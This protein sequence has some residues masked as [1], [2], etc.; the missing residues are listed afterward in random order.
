MKKIRQIKD[1]W[2]EDDVKLLSKYGVKTKSGFQILNIVENST[3]FE[4]RRHFELRWGEFIQNHETFHYD[5]SKEEIYSADYYIIRTNYCC[6]YPQPETDFKYLSVSFN[7]DEICPKCGCGSKQTNN[8]RVN[9]VSKHGFWGFSAWLFDELFV[10]KKIYDDVF[11]PFGIEKREVIKG[12]K[13]L[14]DIFQLVIPVIDES[15]DL[16]E[17]EPVK[18]P[19]CGEIKY[20]PQHF[21][22][23]F[24]PLHEH[25]LPGIY[26]TKEYFGS[27]CEAFRQIVLSKEVAQKLIKSKD[28]KECWLIPCRREK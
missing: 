5:Y 8:L 13:V 21:R 11:A 2:S 16:S 1:R 4:L 27:G 17:R 7:G 24:F 10:S 25:P 19:V 3:Y 28:L 23:P 22:Y 12:G 6:G 14:E 26:K 18:C 20:T 15:I 9:K